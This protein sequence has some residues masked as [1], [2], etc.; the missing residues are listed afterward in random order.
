MF[1][2]YHVNVVM[3]VNMTESVRTKLLGRV[4]ETLLRSETRNLSKNNGL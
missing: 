4:D 2:D 3:V 1:G